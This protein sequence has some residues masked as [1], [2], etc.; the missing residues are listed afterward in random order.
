MTAKQEAKKIKSAVRDVQRA[1]KKIDDVDAAFQAVAR[2]RAVA[3]QLE[4]LAELR[5]GTA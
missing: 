3:V 4:V 1:L 2:L 5:K